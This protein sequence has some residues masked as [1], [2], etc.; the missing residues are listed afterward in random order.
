MLANSILRC[1]IS[2]N[3]PYGY[4]QPSTKPRRKKKM[5]RLTKYV[6]LVVPLLSLSSVAYI[7]T[8]HGVENP[9]KYT[10]QEERFQRSELHQFQ[11]GLSRTLN[12]LEQK[13][14][15]LEAMNQNLEGRINMLA[16]EKDKLNKAY[17]QMKAKQS[18]LEKEHVKLKKKATSLEVAYKKMST[19]SKVAA[20][21][22]KT[23]VAAKKTSVAP[24]TAKKASIKPK[25]AAQKTAAK[26]T[27]N[28]RNVKDT[29]SVQSSPSGVSVERTTEERQSE[30][31][32]GID[33]KKM[34][35]KGIE[36]GKKGMYDEAIKEFQKV[37][38]I[39]PNMANVHYNL[40][41]AYKKK[42]MLSEADN[43][44]TEYERL[45]KQSN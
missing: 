33:I 20:T 39:E 45:K 28:I 38:A 35:E 27:T 11:T 22:K 10:K 3:K 15:N 44:F 24:K 8:V 2:T 29:A 32:S 14:D 36:Y 4:F 30:V 6:A 34:N 23:K 31:D 42:G 40:G 43:E 9:Y 41:L 5:K 12:G 25:S 18:T 37:A 7:K 19:K 13:S 26:K 1:N 17:A 21:P 16:S